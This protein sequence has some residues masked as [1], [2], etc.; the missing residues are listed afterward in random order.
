MSDVWLAKRQR[1]AQMAAAPLEYNAAP[2]VIESTVR[3]TI[4]HF[5]HIHERRDFAPKRDVH[6]AKRPV[7]VWMHQTVAQRGGE[8][9]IYVTQAMKS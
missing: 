9:V 6:A 1:Q 8:S 3:R 5:R 4:T 7:M 2:N